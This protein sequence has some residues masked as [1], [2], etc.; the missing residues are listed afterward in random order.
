MIEIIIWFM[1]TIITQVSKKYNI[2]PTI[3]LAWLCLGAWFWY[4]LVSEYWGEEFTNE[5][6]KFVW[7]SFATSQW[8]YILAKKFNLVK[9][10][11]KKW[12]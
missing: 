7:L 6:I 1:M 10:T 2:E 8:L 11:K 5:L 4:T 3:I 9:K 12:F